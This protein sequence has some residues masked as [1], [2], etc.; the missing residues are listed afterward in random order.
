MSFG[1]SAGDFSWDK[2]SG[3]AVERGLGSMGGEGERA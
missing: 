2:I 3:R 1:F